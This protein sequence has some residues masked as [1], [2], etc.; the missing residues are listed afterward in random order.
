[1]YNMSPDYFP[2]GVNLRVPNM[3]YASD[4]EMGG[5]DNIEIGVAPNNTAPAASSATF[6]ATAVQMVNGS[7]VVVLAAALT[8][9]TLVERWGRGLQFVASGACSRVVTVSGWDYLGQPMDE[10]VTMNGTTVVTTLRAYKRIRQLSWA[11]STD[12][13]TINVGNFDIL[14]LPYRANAMMLEL[15]SNAVPTAGTF[16]AGLAATSTPSISNADVRG[17]YRPH[18]SFIPNGV[19]TYR[20]GLVLDRSNLHGQAQYAA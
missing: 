14:G 13:T 5:A 7:A 8:T 2:V 6:I 10:T 19:R 3:Q 12:T 18:A 15:V 16:V 20:L 1:M 9:D 11:T 4:V 17:T